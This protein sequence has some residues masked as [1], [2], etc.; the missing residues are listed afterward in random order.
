MLVL[1]FS[2]SFEIASD[3]TAKSADNEASSGSKIVFACQTSKEKFF[4]RR[5]KNNF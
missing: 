3:I 4:L 1:F 5:K 2:L